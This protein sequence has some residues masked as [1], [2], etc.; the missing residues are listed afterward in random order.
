MTVQTSRSPQPPVVSP[1]S[2]TK[3]TPVETVWLDVARIAAIT[4]VVVLHA[5]AV[6]VTRRYYSDIGTATW[7]TANVVDSLMR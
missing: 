4:A 3:A 1:R 6:V 2:V 7:W 5:V